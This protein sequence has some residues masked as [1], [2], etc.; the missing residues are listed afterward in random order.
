M[1]CLKK[2]DFP[3][4]MELQA[5]RVAVLPQGLEL[6]YDDIEATDFSVMGVNPI[7]TMKGAGK[8]RVLPGGDSK[9]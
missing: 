3:Q 7:Q 6:K 1:I 9:R 2:Y 8:P 5:H 4:K